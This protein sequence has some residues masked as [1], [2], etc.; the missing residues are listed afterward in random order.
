[1]K[2][3]YTWVDRARGI[4]MILVVL[5]HALADTMS[6]GETSSISQVIF[7]VIYSF[8]MP[9]FFFLS[10]FCG[11]KA[12]EMIE[13]RQKIDYIS[14][15][16]KR[17]MIPYLFVGLWYVPLKIILSSEVNTEV[18]I[19]ALPINFISGHNP[20]FQLWT[21]YALFISSTLICVLSGLGYKSIIIISLASSV[22]SM[23]IA[24]PIT[25][26]QQVM[27]EFFFYAC[28]VT[29]R[30]TYTEKRVN[31]AVLIVIF[32]TFIGASVFRALTGF[33]H[34]KII[35]GITGI[36][37]I[38]ELCKFMKLKDNSILDVVGKYSM[39]IYIMANLVQVLVRSVC[40]YKFHISAITCCVISTVL[41]IVLPI[42]VSKCIVRKVRILKGIVLGDFSR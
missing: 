23:F 32:V 41:G 21:L 31:T 40:L 34:V 36:V 28:G 30:K 18:N 19:L 3:H 24:C 7:D 4:G 22:V 10:G 39:D 37:L 33:E 11:V 29:Y 26:I 12:L 25:I 20:N 16:F 9:L 6:G 8:H 27:F 42:V 13:G 2:T 38:C 1:M 17:L 5:G 35:T 15:R 14:S